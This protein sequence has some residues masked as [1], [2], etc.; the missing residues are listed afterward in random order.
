MLGIKNASAQHK[1]SHLVKIPLYYPVVF[2]D[3]W[4][5]RIKP[6]TKVKF[7]KMK[8]TFAERHGETGKKLMEEDDLF[9]SMQTRLLFCKTNQLRKL[10]DDDWTIEKEATEFYE[11]QYNSP[12][13]M[14]VL[15]G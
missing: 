1:K 6:E 2:K 7:E 12:L 14:K 11:D 13:L 3:D 10:K 9:R 8:E 15:Y 4:K 5:S